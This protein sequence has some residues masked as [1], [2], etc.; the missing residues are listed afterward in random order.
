MLHSALRPDAETSSDLQRAY[1]IAEDP[2]VP[3]FWHKVA[4]HVP[5]KTAQECHDKLWAE[6]PMPKG[7]KGGNP[8]A[9]LLAAEADS[10]NSPLMPPPRKNTAG[11]SCVFPQS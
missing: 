6:D 4:Q 9:C 5:G 8:G 2:T 1:L 3:N 11:T 10:D 7:S